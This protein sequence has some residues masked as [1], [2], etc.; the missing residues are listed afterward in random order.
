LKAKTALIRAEGSISPK[1]LD[2]RIEKIGL[3]LRMLII[4]AT[5]SDPSLLP[6][7]VNQEID[8]RLRSEAKKNAV[9]GLTQHDGLFA[10]LEFSDLRELQDITLSKT[11][12]PKF[13][14][15]FG[16]KETLAAKFDQLAGLRN[17]IRH[18]RSIDDITHKEG[19]AAI[20]WFERVLRK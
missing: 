18:S 16:N 3:Q 15:R 4:L 1:N 19:E 12:W 13:Q 9:V 11:L 8:E 6:P 5:E 7:H 10:R 2:S 17:R 20:I 14:T